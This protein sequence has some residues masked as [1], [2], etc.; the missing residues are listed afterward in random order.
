MMLFE[1]SDLTQSLDGSGDQPVT[2][3]LKPDDLIFGPFLERSEVAIP[4]NYLP[5]APGVHLAGPRM[6]KL[7]GFKPGVS[8]PDDWGRHIPTVY[9]RYP[10]PNEKV[11]PCDTLQVRQVG[12]TKRWAVERL[13]YLT[14]GK[15]RAL[16]FFLPFQIVPIWAQSRREAMFLAEFYREDHALQL[17]GCCWKNPYLQ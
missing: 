15:L 8:C 5:R 12:R 1:P 16:V 6:L 13:D 4:P 10:R 2:A 3:P 14:K 9:R 11:E 7:A 17:V